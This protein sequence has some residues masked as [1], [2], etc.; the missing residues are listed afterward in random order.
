MW[1]LCAGDE[2]NSQRCQLHKLNQSSLN[3]SCNLILNGSEGNPLKWKSTYLGN[4]TNARNLNKSLSST[5]FRVDF[6]PY[7]EMPK[8]KYN[9]E[10]TSIQK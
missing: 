10:H 8:Q 7:N 2:D 4:G 6:Y 1:A 3:L 9:S 5:S